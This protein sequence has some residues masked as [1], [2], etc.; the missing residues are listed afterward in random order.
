MRVAVAP[1]ELE[2]KQVQPGNAIVM[3]LVS[4]SRRRIPLRAR[5]FNAIPCPRKLLTESQAEAGR[6]GAEVEDAAAFNPKRKIG[7]VSSFSFGQHECL[8]KDLALAFVVGLVR[9]AA[10]LKQLRPA[11]GQMGQV[12]TIR[13]GTEKA[14]LNDSWS[15]L[16]FD[17]NSKLAP[18]GFSSTFPP[19]E[20]ILTCLAAWK[21][22]FDGHGTGSFKGERQPTQQ[23]EMQQY[24]FLLQKRKAE[25]LG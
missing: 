9:L 13:V 5:P 11:P 10:D 7:E 6:N 18:P 23:V 16:A 8:G 19:R 24:Y 3:L 4:I 21:L 17:A 15:Y 14:Y 22:H 2:G 20:L 12:R 25:L 1:G